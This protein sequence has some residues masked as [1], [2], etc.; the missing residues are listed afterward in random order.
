MQSQLLSPIK[1]SDEI[2]LKNRVVMAPMTRRFADNL[3]C[4]SPK[5]AGYYSKRSEA[6][7]IVTEGTLISDDAIGYGNIPGI[8]S[9]QQIS[10]WKDITQAV[11]NQDGK[12]FLQLWH[13]GRVSH[14]DYHK[15][16]APISASATQM[17][18]KLGN[19][20]Y[21]VGLSRAATLEEIDA[22]IKDYGKAASNALAAGFD[23]V[24]I[25]GANGYLI[26]QFNHYCTNHR[27]DRYGGSPENM[28]R[29][30]LEVVKECGRQIGLGRVGLRISPAGHMSEI[31]AHDDDKKVFIYLLE[32][33]NSIPVC[34]VHTGNFDDSK[35]FPELEN[36]T[37]TNFIRR[38]YRSNVIASGGYQLKEANEFV[39]GGA[40]NL[41][42]FGRPF[43]AN[44]DLI[45][46]IKSN[47][48]WKQYDPEMLKALT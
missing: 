47:S 42:A 34:Y 3:G 43:I 44:P 25:H 33:L 31:T 23:G 18:S 24:E 17:K 9:P 13:C 20:G 36:A 14:P 10:A 7:L 4:P 30:C 12:L 35:K 22:L 46:L 2:T 5:A 32:Q 37:M 11:H 38:H 27:D 19:S 29:F 41:V 45:Q 1:L 26:D 48:S 40:N 15:G 8:Y 39:N 28:A 6:G 21:D 16:K